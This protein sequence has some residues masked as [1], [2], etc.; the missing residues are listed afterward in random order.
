MKNPILNNKT[1]WLAKRTLVVIAAAIILTSLGIRAGDELLW[2]ASLRDITRQ[3]S[4]C[5]ENMIYITS[6]DGGFC[7]D[8]YENSPGPG[9]PYQDPQNETESQINLDDPDCVP[10]SQEG[11]VPWRNLSQNQATLA[12]ALDGKRLPTPKEWHQVALGTPDKDSG[13]S[14][15][16]CHVASNWPSQPGLTGSGEECVSSAG[17]YDMIGNVWEW[18]D[19]TIFD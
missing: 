15:K 5:P 2:T 12:C 10:V 7:V 1:S 16:D 4:L 11:A 19:G 13:W 18:V 14:G 8:Q 6:P 17:A 9:C 3:E